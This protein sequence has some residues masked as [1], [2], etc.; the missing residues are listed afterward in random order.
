[1]EVIGTIEEP[2]PFAGDE[3][4]RAI[5]YDSHRFESWDPEDCPRCVRCDVKPWYRSADYPCGAEVPR[6]ERTIFAD[7]SEIIK[8]LSCEA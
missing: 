8:I 1:M 2:V 4:Q 7:G 6:Q 3:I 5:N